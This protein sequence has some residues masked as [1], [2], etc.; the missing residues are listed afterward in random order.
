M[1]AAADPYH[2]EETQQK[3][4]DEVSRPSGPAGGRDPTS[5]TRRSTSSTKPRFGCLQGRGGGASTRGTFA[6]APSPPCS[7]CSS[8]SRAIEIRQ[9]SGG[10]PRVD[11][12]RT[13]ST[14]ANFGW[15]RSL[16]R[17]LRADSGVES[18][19]IDAERAGAAG[20]RST[21]PAERA[22]H[23]CYQLLQ[24]VDDAAGLPAT[25]TSPSC[26]RSF[27]RR[28]SSELLGAP[29]GGQVRRGPPTFWRAGRRPPRARTR[30]DELLRILADRESPRPR[31]RRAV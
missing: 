10:H 11:L 18:S 28:L 21:T 17:E 27:G 9:D 30:H 31:R 29:A 19:I 2:Q 25:T 14:A 15:W 24:I 26:S 22:W 12:S 4:R 5:S 1:E 23:R 16:L 7:T 3:V 13:C 8:S 20:G 6:P